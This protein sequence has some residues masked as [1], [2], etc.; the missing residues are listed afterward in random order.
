LIAHLTVIHD[1][2]DLKHAVSQGRFAVINVGNNA[3]IPN[4]LRVGLAW[5]QSVQGFRRHS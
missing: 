2:R 4:L 3:K 5:D 1:S